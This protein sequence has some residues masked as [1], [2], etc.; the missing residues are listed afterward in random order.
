MFKKA[1]EWGQ[2][3]IIIQSKFCYMNQTYVDLIQTLL[4]ILKTWQCLYQCYFCIT[5]IIFCMGH[6]FCINQ[7]YFD[8]GPKFKKKK[9]LGQD[10]V[11]FMY[12]G[13]YCGH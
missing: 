4:Q 12:D 3:K 8:W 6:F 1:L 13:V 7:P 5:E 11:I 9:F 2:S 10:G